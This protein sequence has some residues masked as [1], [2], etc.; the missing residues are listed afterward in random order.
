MEYKIKNA[1][2]LYTDQYCKL[3]FSVSKKTENIDKLKK[4]IE[5]NKTITSIFNGKNETYIIKFNDT[6][7]IYKHR[8]FYDLSFYIHKH[9]NEKTK[10]KYINLHI[11]DMNQCG[12]K[13]LQRTKIEDI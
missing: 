4:K 10:K 1:Q 2:Y 7:H 5:E 11:S 12:K 6:K 3:V 13:E 9:Y 8:I